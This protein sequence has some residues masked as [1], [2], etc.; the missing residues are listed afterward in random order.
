MATKPA[1]PEDGRPP[2]AGRTPAPAPRR[3]KAPDDAHLPPYEGIAIADIL[4]VD[5]PAAAAEALAA[6]LAADVVGLD[7]ES[8]PTFRVGEISRGPHLVQIATDAKAYLFPVDRL[9]SLDELKAVLES[10]RILKV[11]FGLGSDLA[12]LRSKLGI[13]A[14]HVLDLA[15]AL[16]R[17]G[18]GNM[19]GTRSAVA[20]Y[21]GRRLQKS[22]KASTS[23][24]AH[25]RLTEQQMRY[26]ADDAQV[27]LR[28]YRVAQLP[29]AKPPR[30]PA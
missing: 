15:H 19:L 21:F 18:Q 23:N 11:G 2:S 14:K 8:K 3:Q 22:K 30:E 16:R 4:L 1:E 5:S 13:D 7:T 10:K 17:E 9:A 28:V 12:R 29:A 25:P 26:A 6:L 27:A 20:R 24:W